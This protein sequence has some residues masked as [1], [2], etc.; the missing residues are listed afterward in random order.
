MSYTSVYAIY[1]TKAVCLTEL[2][3][4]HGSGPAMWD[5]IA[6][7]CT[8]K[9]LPMFGDV[10]WFWKLWKDERLSKN[11]KAVLL[12]TYDW[13]VVEIDKLEDF[14]KAC[15]EIHSQIID[16]TRWTWNHF[17]DIGK[18]ALILSKKH[19]HRCLGLGIGCTSVSDLWEPCKTVG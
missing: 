15:E 18:Q 6:M 17:S 2:K 1:K 12:S 7:K 5:Y 19:D 4:G 8:G 13:S 10:D 11:E 14:A 3:N 16:N 9:N